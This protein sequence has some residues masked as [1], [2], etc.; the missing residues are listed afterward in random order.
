MADKTLTAAEA[1]EA[2]WKSLK[3]S[4]TGML[5]L[6][7]PGYHSQPMTAF[8]EEE[9]GII[10]F[11]TRDHTDLARDVAGEG[12]AMFTYGA[13]D[14]KVWAC[15]HGTLTLD[16]D[17]ARIDK[18]WNPVLAAWYPD[19]KDDPHL[20]MMRFVGDRCRGRSRW[21]RSTVT[22]SAGHCIR[23]RA[24]A[25]EEIAGRI[26]S[27]APRT[28]TSRSSCTPSTGCRPRGWSWR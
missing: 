20:T 7:R 26:S 10:W 18:Y 2:F 16:R 24:S 4:N 1:E 3:E 27:T 9:T 28:R 21:S 22:H 14:Q 17:Q 11:F 6:D 25:S 19:G 13:K 12:S 5:G 15:I 23:A 8:R